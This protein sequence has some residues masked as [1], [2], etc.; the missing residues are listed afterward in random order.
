MARR[1]NKPNKYCKLF[2]I[3]IE[4][5]NQLTDPEVRFYHVYLRTVDWDVKH[6]ET[7]GF[8]DISLRDLKKHYLPNWSIAKMSG[9]RRSLIKKGWLEMKAGGQIGVKN[10]YIYR[11]KSVQVAEQCIQQMRQGLPIDEQLVQFSEQSDKEK[12]AL[13]KKE[14]LNLVEKMSFPRSV[15]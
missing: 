5:E 2:G 14:T 1:I 11:L 7:F 6:K 10:Y 9:V 4:Y 8:S 15:D 3:E 12:T 13:L